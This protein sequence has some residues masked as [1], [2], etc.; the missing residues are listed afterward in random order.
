MEFGFPQGMAY[1]TGQKNVA[2]QIAMVKNLIHVLR[3]F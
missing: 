2:L 1:G 3:G